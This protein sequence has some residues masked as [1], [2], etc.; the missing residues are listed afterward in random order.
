MNAV[1]PPEATYYLPI[2]LGGDT[3]SHPVTGVFLPNGFSYGN[4][5]VI[6]F[7]HGNRN[8]P[9]MSAGWLFDTID[10]YWGGSFPGGEP[11]ILFREDLN[12]SGK[13]SVLLIAPT[14]GVYPGSSYATNGSSY[15]GM[16]GNQAA[17][18][19]GGYLDQVLA[20]LAEKE[21]KSKGIKIGK[22]I[23]AGHSGGGDPVLRQIELMQ[24]TP[25][26]EVWAFESIYVGA[27]LW[28]DAVTSHTDTQF[29][30]HFATTAQRD[31]AVEIE[32]KLK[33]KSFA[34]D[35]VQ[36]ITI[37]GKKLP[38]QKTTEAKFIDLMGGRLNASFIPN[39]PVPTVGSGGDHYGALTQNFLDRLN[40]SKC[41]K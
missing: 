8:G 3:P 26:C 30:F 28:V 31:R 34:M 39:P 33:D 9:G 15:Y 27:S 23:L 16:F 17:D 37:D 32:S 41:I 24:R 10:K 19:P 12:K 20:K 2:P 35:T 13:H 29:Y 36:P 5:D 4:V 1:G 6:L 25:I 38:R 21:P 14:L 22:I 11:P 40:A 18:A 7:F